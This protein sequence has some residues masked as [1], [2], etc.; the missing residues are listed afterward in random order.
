M[1]KQSL[2]GAVAII[3][4]ASAAQA[5]DLQPVLKA[6]GAVE[7][8][9]TGYVEVYSGWASTRAS[10]DLADAFR[11]DGWALGGAGRGNYWVSREVSVQVDVQAEGTSY[12][13]QPFN[14]GSGHFST[15]S[16]M[17]GGHW[18]WRNPQQYLFGLFAAAGDAGSFAGFSNNSQRHG[19]IGAEAQWYWNQF[20]LYVQGGYD[21]TL[22][23]IGD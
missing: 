21:S 15:Q 1:I 13:P 23:S 5:A 11:V 10:N 12:S 17:I 22:G 16:Y 6:P 19:L 3:A 8:Q 4:L 14:L 9:A 20:T 2:V 18:S 7:Q